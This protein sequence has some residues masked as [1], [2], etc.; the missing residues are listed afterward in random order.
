MAETVLITGGAGFIGSHVA[1]RLLDRGA[2]V[3]VLDSLDPQVHGPAASRP[4]PP[5][6]TWPPQSAWR[7]RCTR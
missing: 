6:F 5:S 3:L 4:A 7:S 1:E 2:D